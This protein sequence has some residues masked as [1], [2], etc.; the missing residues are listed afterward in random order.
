[1]PTN[2]Q[3][4]IK[5]PFGKNSRKGV[6]IFLLTFLCITIIDNVGIALLQSAIKVKSACLGNAPYQ[7]LRFTFYRGAYSCHCPE[8]CFNGLSDYQKRAKGK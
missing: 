8:Q 2:R 6:F 5:T 7:N 3:Q 4:K 1:M